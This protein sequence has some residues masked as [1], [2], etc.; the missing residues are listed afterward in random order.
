MRQNATVDDRGMAD[1]VRDAALSLLDDRFAHS[2]IN[3]PPVL[4]DFEGT[5]DVLIT[6]EPDIPDEWVYEARAALG[7][8][9]EAEETSSLSCYGAVVLQDREETFVLY[10]M[11]IKGLVSGHFYNRRVDFARLDELEQH[12]DVTRH[13][14]TEF[15]EDPR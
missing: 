11:D 3:Q 13:E 7:D 4:L 5:I 8:D 14:L 15:T 2:K 9:F 10:K 6:E 1:R 12:P